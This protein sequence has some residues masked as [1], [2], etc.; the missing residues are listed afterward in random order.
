MST[1]GHVPVPADIDIQDRVL[2]GLTV[3]QLLM[4]AP[5][6]LAAALVWQSLSS[7]LPL[8]LVMPL[9]CIPVALSAA[10]AIGRVD[11]IG[12]DRLF[13]A[14]AVMPRRPMAAGRG[15]ALGIQLERRAASN[16][17]AGV[18]TGPV[19]RVA[20]DGLIDLG[21]A[22][23]ARAVDVGSVNFDLLGPAE[24]TS[25]VAALAR[26]CYG[27]DAHLQVV[28][29]TRPVDLSGYIDA[30]DERATAH[31]NTAV[32]T[33]ARAHAHWLAGLVRVQGLLDRQITV[34][35]TAHSAEAA[36]RAAG[37]VC[38]FAASIGAGAALLDRA[39]V[40][41]RVRAGVDP[42]GTPGRRIA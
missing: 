26:L 42:F 21:A 19:R 31:P 14:A 20:D 12:L 10:V 23:F 9:A 5:S 25:L 28:V 35:V 6:G 3:R 11:G 16:P 37:A 41:E 13:A 30:L 36:E 27:L 34:V 1:A 17:E 7:L 15:A 32:A 24:Q 33:S 39:G 22:G 2:F 8:E 29:A 18:L 38:D 4:L 40:C